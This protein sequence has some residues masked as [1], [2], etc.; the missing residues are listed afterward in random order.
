MADLVV[1]EGETD[2]PIWCHVF[3]N[4]YSHSLLLRHVPPHQAAVERWLD[5]LVGFEVRHCS[6]IA[7]GSYHRLR[8]G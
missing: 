6:R 8:N 4:I 1:Y 3:D 7:I 5:R 2:L